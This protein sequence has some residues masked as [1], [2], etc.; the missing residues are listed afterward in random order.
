M[1]KHCDLEDYH[2]EDLPVEVKIDGTKQHYEV[3]ISDDID[4]EQFSLVING[5]FSE[6]KIKIYYCPM[7]GKELSR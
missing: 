5:T 2:G 7:C 1:C 3:S 6:L 4:N